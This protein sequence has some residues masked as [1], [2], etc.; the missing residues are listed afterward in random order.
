VLKTVRKWY[1]FN[2]R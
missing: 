1:F 2:W